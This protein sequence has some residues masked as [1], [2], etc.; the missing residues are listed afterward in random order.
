[1]LLLIAIV[2]TNHPVIDV[3][4]GE[5]ASENFVV[6][7]DDDK[8]KAAREAQR[9]L[10]PC[11]VDDPTITDPNEKLTALAACWQT[12]A[13]AKLAATKNEIAFQKMVRQQLSAKLQDYKCDA[14]FDN[15]VNVTTSPSVFNETYFAPDRNKQVELLFESDYSSVRLYR[16]FLTPSECQ[17]IMIGQTV[18]ASDSALQKIRRLVSEVLVRNDDPYQTSTKSI[19]LRVDHGNAN[20]DDQQECTVQADGSCQP[21][22]PDTSSSKPSLMRVTQTEE[23]VDARLLVTCTNGADQ[24]K[25]GVLFYPKAGVQIVPVSGEAVFTL[26]KDSRGRRDDD[27]FLNDHVVCPVQRGIVVAIEDTYYSQ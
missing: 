1:L 25:G 24:V 14:S 18:T 11:S 12:Q 5:N 21:P 9:V 22:P 13:D 17:A 3:E 4:L 19:R 6:K 26:Y 7:I 27:P 8:L 23:S 10:E 2:A 15:T 20:A 16:D